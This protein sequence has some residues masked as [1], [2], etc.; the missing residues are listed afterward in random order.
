VAAIF[1]PIQSF[2]R[3]RAND[4]RYWRGAGGVSIWEQEKLEDRKMP[5]NAAESRQSGARGVGQFL[6]M[7]LSF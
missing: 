3:E 6:W 2:L 7:T 4:L 5:E 1:N